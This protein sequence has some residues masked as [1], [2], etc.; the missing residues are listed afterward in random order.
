MNEIITEVVRY[1]KS[2]HGI[3]DILNNTNYSGINNNF[4]MR[5]EEYQRVVDTSNDQS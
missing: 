1:E 4:S 5:V 2:S 3:C